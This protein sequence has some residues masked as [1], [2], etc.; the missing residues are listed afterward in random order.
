MEV[1]ESLPPLVRGPLG[2]TDII[3]YC[4]G[5]AP[6]QIQAHGIALRQYRKHPAWVFRDPN[7]CALEPIYGVHYNQA[8]AQASGLPYSYDTAVQ[9]HCWLLQLL[10]NWMGDDGWV[11]RSYAKYRNFVYLSDVVW[12]HGKITKKYVNDQGEGCVDIKTSAVN[13]RGEDVMPG[14]STVLL[15]SKEKGAVLPQRCRPSREDND[16]S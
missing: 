16:G 14:I 4:I 15:P 11:K 3:A 5:A 1:R 9:R 10:T 7:T 13:Q 6:V 8:A 2:L 12:I